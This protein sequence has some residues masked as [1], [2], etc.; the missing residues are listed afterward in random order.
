MSLEVLK[1]SKKTI[2]TR[3]TMKAVEKGT[4]VKVFIAKD[5]EAHIIMPL[6]N[7]CSRKNIP[8]EE[9]DSMA[10]LGEACGIDVGAASVGVIK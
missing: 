7:L 5:A 2:G 10:M 4:A 9:V 3:E 8:I 1:N 6:S